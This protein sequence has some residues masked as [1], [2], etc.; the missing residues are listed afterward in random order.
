M[1][2]TDNPNH[3]DLGFGVDKEKT[4]QSKVYLV[5]SEEERAKGF[6]RPYHSAYRHVGKQGPKYPLLDLTDDQ[7]ERFGDDWAKYEKYPESES[8]KVGKFWTQAQLDSI[9]KGCG[10][11][12][13]IA[14][15]IA[16]TFAR[17][18][19]FYGST[20]CTFCMKHLPVDEFVWAGTDIRVGS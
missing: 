11:A 6:I 19:H 12:T 4:G 16:E 8:P 10:A 2:V 13:I 17:N 15:E 3:P 9:G 18:P 14:P 5:L 1:P 20:Y 7:K